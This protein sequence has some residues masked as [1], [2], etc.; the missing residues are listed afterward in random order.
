MKIKVK[1]LPEVWNYF[2]NTIDILY[3]KNYF[4]FEEDAIRYVT[5]LFDQIC[6]TDK[7]EICI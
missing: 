4:G 6:G 7:T 5:D 2:N 3:E 1:A